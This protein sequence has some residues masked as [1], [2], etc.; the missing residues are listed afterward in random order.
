MADGQIS[1][2]RGALWLGI[3]QAIKV[4]MQLASILVLARLLPAEDYG[5]MAMAS[6]V[7]AFAAL[8]RDFGTG[9]SLIQRPELDETLCSTVFWFNIALGAALSCCLAILSPGIAT[10]FSEPRLGDVLLALSPVFL[11]MSAGVVQMAL[12]ERVS[13]FKKTASIEVAS[14]AIALAA[15]S[16]AA[17]NGVGVYALVVQS[18][19]AGTL[20]TLLLWL[21]NAWRPRWIFE[22]QALQQIWKFSGNMFTFNVANYLQRNAD[23]VLIGRFLGASE[24]GIYS[25]AYRILLFPLQNITFVITRA[26]FPAYSRSQD[27]KA[28]LGQHYLEMLGSIAIFT[29]PLMTAI[30]VV[31]EP[32]IEA[33]FGRRWLP[34]SE[35]LAWLAPVGFFQSMVSTSGTL[36]SAVGRADILRNLGFLGIPFLVFSLA[37]GMPWGIFG[38]AAGYCIG[39]FFWVYPV[40]STVLRQLGL[41][42]SGFLRAI[43]KPAL[44]SVA[45]GVIVRSGNELFWVSASGVH[46]V[47]LLNLTLFIAVYLAITKLVY[48]Q[49]FGKIRLLVQRRRIA[50]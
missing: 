9:A 31:R 10:L 14:A 44:L 3:A 20:S 13:N 47:L 35:V 48:P 12:L 15:A 28:E 23:S 6:T 22:R 11:A 30:W 24:L 17:L 29:A 27:K 2:R 33:L 46:W 19:V 45:S 21:V 37:A 16:I 41:P 5:L 36:L 40:I 18:L 43:Y 34:A 42:F 50:V 39:N 49:A 26:A 4:G 32:F 25:V 38:V 1:V 8:F 7:T